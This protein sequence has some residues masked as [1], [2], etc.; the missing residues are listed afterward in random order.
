VRSGHGRWNSLQAARFFA[1][2]GW[3]VR[4]S[5]GGRGHV[6]LGKTAA[7]AT[8]DRRWPTRPLPSRSTSS[9]RR[10]GPSSPGSVITF[11]P[12]Q[13]EK[14]I[15]ELEQELG[16]PGFWDDQQH[17]AQVSAEHARLTRRLERYRGL[18]Q[19]YQDAQELLRMDG[20]MEDEIATSIAPLRNELDRLQEDALFSGEYDAGDA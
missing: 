20:E 15:A 13:L 6:L 3:S 2:C 16:A 19:D 9:S 11:D 14:R 5:C 10:S 8:I 1:A 18:L 4:L 7:L 17:A 12:D